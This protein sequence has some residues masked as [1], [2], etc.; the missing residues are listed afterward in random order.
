MGCGSWPPHPNHL[1][2]VITALCGSSYFFKLKTCPRLSAP[3]AR[4][5]RAQGGALG[6]DRGKNQALKGR[7]HANGGVFMGSPLQGLGFFIPVTQGFA[8]GFLGSRPWRYKS[9]AICHPLNEEYPQFN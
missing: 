9:R 2:S 8:L 4:Y 7:P 1:A 5:K 6:L 3:K